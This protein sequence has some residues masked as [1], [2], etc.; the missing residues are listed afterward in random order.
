MSQSGEQNRFRPASP[1]AVGGEAAT[2]AARVAELCAAALVEARRLASDRRFGPVLSQLLTRAHD[3]L[4]ALDERRAAFR[5]GGDDCEGERVAAL[6]RELNAI[7]A[8]LP[9]G[10]YSPTGSR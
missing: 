5:H 2:D 8:M 9:P 10:F 7:R 4:D 1:R 6:K 3:L